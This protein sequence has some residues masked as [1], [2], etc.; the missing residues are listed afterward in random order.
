MRIRQMRQRE[1]RHYIDPS[2][3]PAGVSLGMWDILYAKCN[4]KLAPPMQGSNAIGG[5]LGIRPR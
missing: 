1:C 5:D 4:G 3:E 2:G